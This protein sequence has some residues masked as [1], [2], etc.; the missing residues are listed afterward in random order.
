M[1]QKKTVRKK[2]FFLRRKKY[3]EI[4]K[5]FFIPFLDLIKLKFKKKKIK[6][7]LY[8]PSSFEI[9]VLKLLEINF[10]SKQNLLLPVIEENDSMNFFQWKKNEEKLKKNTQN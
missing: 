2:Y 3:Y 6:L 8:Y 5:D 1:K 7:A 9:N 10:I 4:S